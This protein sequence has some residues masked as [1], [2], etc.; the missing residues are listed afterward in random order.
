MERASLRQACGFSGWSRTKSRWAISITSHGVEATAET[1]RTVRER[2][3]RP[4]RT[5]VTESYRKR[6]AAFCASE[7]IQIPS[8]FYRHS[9]SR[10][11]AV[12]L[13]CTPPKLI[14]ATW[15]K[16]EDLLYYLRHMGQGRRL[17]VLDFKDRKELVLDGTA[18]LKAGPA[19]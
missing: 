8:G 12:D 15:F 16:Q 1:S 10:Y 14:A 17:R 19:F 2:S 4:P 3:A 18:R 13:D 9:A 11:A 7:G 6:I 5:V